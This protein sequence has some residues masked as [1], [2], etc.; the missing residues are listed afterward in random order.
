MRIPDRVLK[1]T[2]NENMHVGCDCYYQQLKQF[3]NKSF[4]GP[5]FNKI[6]VFVLYG[7]LME[8]EPTRVRNVK[9]LFGR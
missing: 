9:L 2:T 7:I 3:N 5:F 8:V 6:S 4:Y 1:K